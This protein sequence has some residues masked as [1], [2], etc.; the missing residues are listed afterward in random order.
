MSWNRNS[1]RSGPN[2]YSDTFTDADCFTNTTP[3][4][5][6][7]GISFSNFNST[8]DFFAEPFTNFNFNTTSNNFANS[9]TISYINNIRRR[10]SK[11][12]SYNKFLNNG[13]PIPW[14]SRKWKFGTG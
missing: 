10:T 3:N 6:A 11:P 5:V 8:S 1:S 4:T 2:A 13:W 12:F 7:Y 9:I 14:S